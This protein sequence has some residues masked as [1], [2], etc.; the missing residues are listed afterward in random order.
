MTTF[1]IWVWILV[2]CQCNPIFSCSCCGPRESAAAQ[3]L[4]Q[5]H[6]ISSVRW[7][8]NSF[9]WLFRC[10][11]SYWKTHVHARRIVLH[12]RSVIQHCLATRVCASPG[13]TEIL[14]DDLL[15]N[16]LAA[17][18]WFKSTWYAV[19]MSEIH[20]SDCKSIKA[21]IS[22]FQMKLS[23]KQ[24]VNQFSL[25]DIKSCW[26]HILERSW[27]D[28]GPI[29][30]TSCLVPDP[31]NTKDHL[32]RLL[33]FRHCQQPLP[34]TRGWSGGGR[35]AA[36]E[37]A[38]YQDSGRE[39]QPPVTSHAPWSQSSGHCPKRKGAPCD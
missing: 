8:H 25:R 6:K 37:G 28:K 23:L 34:V 33:T 15:M 11:L 12:L 21:C 1:L 4:A 31:E 17:V 39:D 16:I 35:G 36:M 26:G 19:I 18:K 2:Y 27:T 24:S 32:R 20:P 22:F 14:D 5:H 9:D 38:G 10:S 30:C 13:E 7:L 29:S 3:L